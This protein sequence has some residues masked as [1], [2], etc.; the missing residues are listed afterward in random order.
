M[1][2][3][4]SR[5]SVIIFILFLVFGKN[6]IINRPGCQYRGGNFCYL[7]SFEAQESGSLEGKSAGVTLY[8]IPELGAGDLQLH[9]VT[10]FH[11]EGG[12]VGGGAVVHVHIGAVVMVGGVVSLGYNGSLHRQ[13][14]GMIILAPLAD[15]LDKYE[16]KY[17]G[18]HEGYQQKDDPKHSKSKIK[19]H[20]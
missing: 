2:L 4:S 19:T 13:P 12:V 11:L 17:T 9:P 8:K 16:H 18:G 14:G 3:Y 1:V 5:S 20:F 10:A 15:Y 6:C 7:H